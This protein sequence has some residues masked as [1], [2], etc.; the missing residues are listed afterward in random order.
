MP[1]PDVRVRLSAEGTAE[2]VA[3]LRKVQAEGKKSS[4]ASG[5]SFLGFNSV[6][7]GTTRLLAGL[8]AAVG[9][10]TFVN[11]IR[12]GAQAADEIGKLGQ[13]IGASVENL[14][15]LRLG[16]KQADV[17]LAQLR[18]GFTFL[19]RRITELAK[20]APDAQAM[21]RELGL[22]AKDFRGK[23]AVQSFELVSQ[24]MAKLGDGAR[25][26]AIAVGIFGR[27]GAQLIPLMNDLAEE[28]LANLIER[29][30]DLG[31]LFDEEMAASIEKLNDDMKILKLQAQGLGAQFASGMAPTMSQSLQIL[32]GEISKT[33]ELWKNMGAAVGWITK[34]I[35]AGLATATDA[36]SVLGQELVFRTLSIIKLNVRLLKGEVAEAIEDFLAKDVLIEDFLARVKERLSIAF[37]IPEPGTPNAPDSA[38]MR[39]WAAG[40]ALGLPMVPAP[41]YKPAAGPEEDPVEL[42]RKQTEATKTI[43]D[44]EFAY[45]KAQLKVRQDA[46]KRSYEE[47]ASS[48]RQH[49][50][51]RRKFVRAEA[52]AEVAALLERK[53]L[54]ELQ[55][56][57]IKAQA[58]AKAI[59]IQVNRIRLEQEGQIAS[60]NSEETKAMRALGAKALEIERE[61]L[62][63]RGRRHEAAMLAIDEEMKMADLIFKNQGVP[64]DKRI[65]LLEQ[66][67]ASRTAGADF[68]ASQTSAE[69]AMTDLGL[70]RRRIQSQMESGLITQMDG[71]RQ[72][73]ELDQARLP[74]L[75]QAAEALVTAALA[76]GNPENIQQAR[77]F[78]LSV[79]EIGMAA[80]GAALSWTQFRDALEQSGIQALSDMFATGIREGQ[81][82]KDVMA[83][84]AMSVVQSIRRIAS[85][86]LATRIIRLLSSLIPGGAGGGKVGQGK[87]VIGGLATGAAGGL[88][89]GAHFSSGGFL[90]GPGTGTSDSL[91]AL[92]EAGRPV[93]LSNGEFVVRAASVQQPGALD[94]LR[95]FN[96]WSMATLRSAQPR[97]APLGF[98]EGGI[99]GAAAA[100]STQASDGRLTIGLDE[101][102]VLKALESPRGRKILVEVVGRNRRTFQRVIEG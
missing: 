45:L 36:V 74:V 97:T 13:K 72:L 40:A 11:L 102:L 24:R 51:Q 47:G 58:E 22:S 39:R 76:T 94:F 38:R 26:T 3:A 29:A 84:M 60:L 18:V 91:V 23:D 100:G 54:L 8:G 79:E 73:L 48:L 99:V 67:R 6:L 96:R 71:E 43:R 37:D 28:G 44:A 41:T 63:A 17:D 35:V 93:R 87:E 70:A 89:R 4:Q 53:P 69:A 82:F 5:R 1:T 7:G 77:E 88:L 9:V 75:Q 98:A 61:L 12:T 83:E 65:R 10:G 42:A 78:A 85:E 27:S 62:E 101:G 21:F 33:T 19:N 32:S 59:D 15:A 25:K 16:A 14:S 81:K 34:V 92:T 31:V 30:R 95:D 90:R 57:Q 2:V 52:D 68:E 55:D 64:D 49:Y 46:E 86:I 50:E 80:E 66:L 56:D 20:G